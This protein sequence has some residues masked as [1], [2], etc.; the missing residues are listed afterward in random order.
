MHVPSWQ[1]SIRTIISWHCLNF[2]TTPTSRI[3]TIS[4]THTPNLSSH[5]SQPLHT[6]WSAPHRITSKMLQP[7]RRSHIENKYLLRSPSWILTPDIRFRIIPPTPVS[8]C[9]TT[10]NP[11]TPMLPATAKTATTT[12]LHLTRPSPTSVPKRSNPHRPTSAP[13]PKQNKCTT[14]AKTGPSPRARYPW[15]PAPCPGV[16]C[17]CLAGM[18]HRCR[19]MSCWAWKEPRS[20]WEVTRRKRRRSRRRG[21]RRSVGGSL[22]VMGRRRG[23]MLGVMGRGGVWRGCSIIV[24]MK[25]MPGGK[26]LGRVQI[27]T[28]FGRSP[29]F[30][31][32]LSGRITRV[33]LCGIEY[34]GHSLH[35]QT[36]VSS[37]LSNALQ[38][39][40]DSR[41]AYTPLTTSQ[42]PQAPLRIQLLSSLQLYSLTLV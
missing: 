30:L 23:S 8:S 2:W 11:P 22:V 19:P 37:S 25:R 14:P 35:L 4:A 42:T 33:L 40:H 29:W 1:R 9:P 20:M 7:Q 21:R 41:R 28:P 17:F 13:G 10:P 38:N 3:M 26:R 31:L 34:T 27:A 5:P 32:V 18:T 24:S 12:R 15:A 39:P 6:V 36:I 16:P